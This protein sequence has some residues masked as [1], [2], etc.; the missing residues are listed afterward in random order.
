M[1]KVKLNF[2]N[3]HLMKYFDSQ[4]FFGF[5]FGVFKEI[6]SLAW[7]IFSSLLETQIHQA[8]TISHV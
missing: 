8:D 1:K 4:I 3:N 5:A 7:F 2:A 6:Q